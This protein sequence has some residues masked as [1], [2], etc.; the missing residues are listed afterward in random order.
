MR[1]SFPNCTCLS[2]A[3]CASAGTCRC[4]AD[5]AVVLEYE[6]S[7]V[8][9]RVESTVTAASVRMLSHD[10]CSIRVRVA[11][12]TWRHAVRATNIEDGLG[13]IDI[14][15]RGDIGDVPRSRT[16]RYLRC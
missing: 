14:K 2:P 11:S 9:R 10:T 5:L 7:S 13:R 8:G 16:D 12:S 4:L 3:S 1:H 15:V 6:P